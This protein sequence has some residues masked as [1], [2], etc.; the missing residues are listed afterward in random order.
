MVLESGGKNA[1]SG[2]SKK[3]PILF[4][5]GQD[6]WRKYACCVGKLLGPVA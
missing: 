6:P 5:I 2:L 4:P 1:D 3:N